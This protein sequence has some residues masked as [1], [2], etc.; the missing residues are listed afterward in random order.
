MTASIQ[1]I[2]GL[3]MLFAGSESLVRG[4]VRLACAFGISRIVIG[5]TIIAFATSSPE[6]VVGI[7]AALRGQNGLVLGNMLGSNICNVA[8][9]L[10]ISAFIQPIKIEGEILKKEAPLVLIASLAILLFLQNGVL[11][12]REGVLLV[13]V[14][15]IYN[16]LLIQ[17][18]RNAPDSAT[19]PSLNLTGNR[20]PAFLM[21]AAGIVLL[22][23]G[24]DQLLRGAVTLARIWSVPETVIGLSVLAIGTSLP[25]LAAAVNASV[26]KES[27]LVVGNIMG[28]NLFNILCVLGFAAIIQPIHSVGLSKIDAA[29]FLAAAAVTIPLMKSGYTISR[30]EATCLLLAYGAYIVYL[31]ME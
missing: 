1:I 28:S 2:A 3:A 19:V 26:K 7:Q 29:A 9:I 18:A 14:F 15:V 31:S 16:T 5:L 25:E 13:A 11:T 17:N 12:R 27:D 20:L 23:A 4:S 24:A 22:S 8:L 6:M 30:K 10:G 21:V